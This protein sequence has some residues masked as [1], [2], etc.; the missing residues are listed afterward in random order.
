MG[1]KGNTE[2]KSIKET[3]SQDNKLQQLISNVFFS[4]D[5]GVICHR[6]K[7]NEILI[8]NQATLDI[9]GFKTKEEMMAAGF[10]GV[11]MAILEE[12]RK[13]LHQ[14]MDSLHKSKEKFNAEYRVKHTDGSIGYIFGDVQLLH[15]KEGNRIYQRTLL[16][17]TEE[18]MTELRLIQEQAKRAMDAEA[19]KA[20]AL[21][22]SNEHKAILMGL[23]K[24]FLDTYY[25]NL[26]TAHCQTVGVNCT[27]K[28]SDNTDGNYDEI[29]KKYIDTSVWKPDQEMVAQK[30]SRQY[31]QSHLNTENPF[32][33]IIFRRI[34]GDVYRWYRMDMI[35]STL[36]DDGLVENI[37]IAFMDVD[38]KK[39]RDEDYQ[40]RLKE[41]NQ[42]LTVALMQENKYREE[43][44]EAY[45][46]VLK[47][48]QAKN[49]FLSNMSHDIRTPMNG[50]I[51]MTTVAKNYI[52]N[53]TKVAEY[54]N[55]IDKTS[56]YLLELINNVLDMSKIESNDTLI[57]EEELLLS[58]IVQSFA[59]IVQPKV[60][61]KKHSCS[62]QV[63]DV[64]HE[65]LLGDS[66]HL[67]QIFV[68][69]IGNA[70]KYTPE[71]GNITVD[72]TEESSSEEFAN[73]R[74][75]ISD[76]GIGMSK[77]FLPHLFEM[78][79]QERTKARTHARGSGLGMAITYN[80]VAM[81]GGTMEVESELEKGSTFTI[82]LPLKISGKRK[83]EIKLG[84]YIIHVEEDMDD[85]MVVE[86]V[87]ETED[88]DSLA[89]NRFLI[90]EDNEINMEII[91]EILQHKEA[92]VEKA[93]NGQIAFDMFMDSKPGYYDIILMDI[94]MPVLNGYDASEKIRHSDHPDANKIPI[95][96]LSADAFPDDVARA[97]DAGMNAHIAKPIDFSKLYAEVKKHLQKKSNTPL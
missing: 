24:L 89:G 68:N 62:I 69:V 28:F 12:D 46:A 16:D 72:I 30:A 75:V 93:E 19:K 9:L 53:P 73:L 18:K 86:D 45:D 95:I 74:F 6:E 92:T 97:L 27:K 29:L 14:M 78:F 10:D 23:N 41:I 80:L 5:C 47:A 59:M 13:M 51:G 65:R 44:K 79:T 54:L 26:I 15:D 22:I 48:N 67:N 85:W 33:S 71:G 7:D 77:E 8:I 66:L 35:L 82:R 61:D 31:V 11:S 39:R 25:V 83:P 96:A 76:N 50:I 64:E 36:K 38:D 87:T 63:H 60:L 21:A 55:K 70:I 57:T 58:D 88:I 90:V 1:D 32:Y 34:D 52:N 84:P 3:Y 49:E 20:E 42:H 17:I 37:V 91:S 43:L 4:M 2:E 81:M 56:K 94:K 40:K